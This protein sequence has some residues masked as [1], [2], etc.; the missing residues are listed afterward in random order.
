[1]ATQYSALVFEFHSAPEMGI[2]SS[3]YLNSATLMSFLELLM[4]LTALSTIGEDSARVKL[5]D[6]K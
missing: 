6:K 5:F 1:M 3:P 4:V 2:S